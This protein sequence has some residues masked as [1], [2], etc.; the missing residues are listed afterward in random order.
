[1]A[2]T[3]DVGKAYISALVLQEKAGTV[4][5]IYQTTVGLITPFASLIAG[6]LWTYIGVGA[7]FIF[8]SS[9]AAISEFLFVILER[10]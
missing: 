4:F 1:M 9:M 8:G 10:R 2:L 5:G 6:F 3:D 7:P